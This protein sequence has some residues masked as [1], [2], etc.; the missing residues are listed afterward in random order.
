MKPFHLGCTD[1]ARCDA[2][3]GDQQGSPTRGPACKTNVEMCH[4]ECGRALVC[5]WWCG[6][7]VSPQERRGSQHTTALRF[8]R[9]QLCK[10]APGEGSSKQKNR[11]IFPL[12]F[13]SYHITYRSDTKYVARML[14]YASPGSPVCP[15]PDFP[16]A[17]FLRHRPPPAYARG[18]GRFCLLAGP[19]RGRRCTPAGRARRRACERRAAA[20]GRAAGVPLAQLFFSR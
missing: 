7:A 2:Q 3:N 4:S 8:R 17:D 20:A 18:P 13:E 15:P 16:N 14:R 1:S 10:F 19:S 6:G 9:L 5:V 11:L 12:A